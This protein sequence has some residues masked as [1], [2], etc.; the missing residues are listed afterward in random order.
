VLDAMV[1]AAR[2]G[3]DETAGLQSRRGRAAWLGERSSGHADPGATAY[4]RLLEALR[5]TW[6]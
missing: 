1:E 2:R 3:V 5:R 4:L 6:T